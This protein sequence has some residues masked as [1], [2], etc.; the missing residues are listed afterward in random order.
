MAIIASIDPDRPADEAATRRRE[1][2]ALGVACGAHLLHDGYTDL[3]W[4]ALPIWQAEFGLSYAAVG[5]LRMIYSG[6]M[7]SLQI[8]SSHLGERVGGGLVLALGTALC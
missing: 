2:R 4:V 5:L 7:A 1:R 3:I 6:T 8:P